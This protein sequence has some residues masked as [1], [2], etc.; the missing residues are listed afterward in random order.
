MNKKIYCDQ[1]KKEVKILREETD[2]NGHRFKIL[3]CGHETPREIRVS[4]SV[5]GKDTITIVKNLKYEV[6]QIWDSFSF[7]FISVLIT[8]ALTVGFGVGSLTK[9]LYLSIISAFSSILLIILFFRHCKNSLI[10]FARWVLD[11][12]NGG[13]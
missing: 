10:K 8:A 2:K 6:R 4:D 13:K 9:N 3:G 7:T 5:T 11:K 1:C 12:D